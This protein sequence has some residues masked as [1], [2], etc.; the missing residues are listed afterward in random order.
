M[1]PISP[2]ITIV[3][4]SYNQGE[5]LEQTILSVLGQQYSNLEYM[6]FD[7]ASTDGSVEI[8]KKYERHLAYWASEKDKGQ[9]NAI[10]NGF[11]RATGDIFMW[12]NSDDM[13]MPG[14]LSFISQQWLQNGEGIYFGNC[15]HF[16][17]ADYGLTSFGSDV[18]GFHKRS[19]LEDVDYIIQPSSFWPKSIWYRVGN[20]REDIHFGFDWEWFLRAK[21]LGINFYPLNK[22]LSLYRMHDAHKSST[23]GSRRQSEILTIYEE[24]SPRVAKLYNLLCNETFAETQLNSRMVFKIGL[25]LGRHLSYEGLLKKLK[26]NKYKEYTMS[27]I[28]ETRYMI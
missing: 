2:K 15:L 20:L 24:Y 17:E 3:T 13:L 26:P 19:R 14:I 21:K 18:V 6:I 11:E 23:G 12:L 16:R 9:S 1:T 10:N 27:E 22:C 7:G 5:Y 25:L 4:P 8:I 28:T